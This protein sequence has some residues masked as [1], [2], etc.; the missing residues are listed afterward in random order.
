VKLKIG[1]NMSDQVTLLK[2]E[3]HISSV[4]GKNG[5]KKTTITLTNFRI[6]QETKVSGGKE[7]NY[8]P[9]GNIDSY[10]IGTS[11]YF[12]ILLLGIVLLPFYGLGIVFIITYWITRKTGLLVHSNSG[13]TTLVVEA[14][15][16]NRKELT[17]LVNEIQSMINQIKNPNE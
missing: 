12:L 1:G 14:S 10:G 17:K 13:K 4:V 16:S 6:F 2:G 7:V 5:N 8:I 11:Q 3:K 15:P 9:L